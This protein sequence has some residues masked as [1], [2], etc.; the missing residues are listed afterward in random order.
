MGYPLEVTFKVKLAVI[1]KPRF[2]HTKKEHICMCSYVIYVVIYIVWRDLLCLIIF[3]THMECIFHWKFIKYKKTRKLKHAYNKDT[4]HSIILKSQ[5]ECDV[6]WTLI[7][8]GTFSLL[9][10]IRI[11]YIHAVFFIVLSMHILY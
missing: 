3:H 11:I 1:Q 2:F 6:S 5:P 10:E 7:D 8:L 4:T 9:L